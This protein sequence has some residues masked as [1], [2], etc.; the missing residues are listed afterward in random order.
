MFAPSS[1]TPPEYYEVL[2]AQSFAS[3]VLGVSQGSQKTEPALNSAEV[4]SES[5]SKPR[6]SRT[7]IVSAVSRDYK[8][9]LSLF[10]CELILDGCS[11]SM[12]KVSGKGKKLH[13]EGTLLAADAY[14]EPPTIASGV[15]IVLQAVDDTGNSVQK[16]ETFSVSEGDQLAWLRIL[17]SVLYIDDAWKH[18]LQSAALTL[19]RVV[20]VGAF[21][22]VYAATHGS[23][24][25]AV[26]VL[27][28]NSADSVVQMDFAHEAG[29]LCRLQNPNVLEFVGVATLD[30]DDVAAVAPADDGSFNP[31]QPA[32]AMAAMMNT[33]SSA[34][35]GT[36]YGIVVEFCGGGT[37]DGLITK[38]A[39]AHTSLDTTT[40]YRI[41]LGIAR[42]CEYIHALGI[43]HRDIKPENIVLTRSVKYIL[44]EEFRNATFLKIVDFGQA[45]LAHIDSSIQAI[46]D[47]GTEASEMTIKTRG[48]VFYRAPEV[49][50]FDTIN[51]TFAKTDM[52]LYSAKADIYSASLVMWEC[53]TRERPFTDARFHRAHN[54]IIEKAV[55]R[56]ERPEIPDDC[57]PFLH[58]LL[59]RGWC[60][61]P[62]LRLPASAMLDV[63]LREE[64]S[65]REG[66]T[67]LLHPQEALLKHVDAP[68]AIVTVASQH[69][70][71]FLPGSCR[72]EMLHVLEKFYADDTVVCAVDSHVQQSL[73]QRV[74]ELVEH[75]DVLWPAT[76][77]S[78]QVGAT[79]MPLLALGLVTRS[80]VQDA[81][82]DLILSEHVNLE[83]YANSA[84]TLLMKLVLRMCRAAGPA[85]EASQYVMNILSHLAAMAIPQ[86]CGIADLVRI[87]STSFGMLLH[88]YDVWCREVED[89]T[90]NSVS[91]QRSG[92]ID[93]ME[94]VEQWARYF[95]TT[96]FHYKEYAVSDVKRKVF[97]CLVASQVFP[98][99]CATANALLSPD[100]I[101]P[102]AT[103]ASSGIR[104]TD[105]E[106]ISA[107]TQWAATP[108]LYCTVVF[109]GLISRQNNVSTDS[110]T[111]ILLSWLKRYPLDT[112]L[113]AEYT[114]FL[115][116][117][118]A[119][120]DVASFVGAMLF[121]IKQHISCAP[122]IVQQ[123][124]EDVFAA[125]TLTALLAWLVKF[126]ECLDIGLVK[127][128]ITIIEVLLCDNVQLLSAQHCTAAD[129]KA[130]LNIVEYFLTKCRLSS[131]DEASTLFEICYTCLHIPLHICRHTA[132]PQVRAAFVCF[133]PLICTALLP[134]V[135]MSSSL[136]SRISDL[137]VSGRNFVKR[138]FLDSWLHGKLCEQQILDVIIHEA[139]TLVDSMAIE[140][141]CKLIQVI[142]SA[143][144]SPTRD[145]SF[146]DEVRQSKQFTQLLSAAFSLP[147]RAQA[148][149]FS[150]GDVNDVLLLLPLCFRTAAVPL[151]DYLRFAPNVLGT[152][153][154]VAEHTTDT[155][156]ASVDSS[157][158]ACLMKSAK[159]HAA[160]SAGYHLISMLTK[161]ILGT[162]T[163][164]DAMPTTEH[165][166]QL[167]QH[168]CADELEVPDVCVTMDVLRSLYCDV[169]IVPDDAWEEVIDTIELMWAC[170]EVV[171]HRSAN[172]MLQ[173]AEVAVDLLYRQDFMRVSVGL[174]HNNSILCIARMFHSIIQWGH[175]DALCNMAHEG[176]PWLQCL[177]QW[178]WRLKQ[179]AIAQDFLAIAVQIVGGL[180]QQRSSL[181]LLFDRSQLKQA[182]N[183][184]ARDKE[185][186][187]TSGIILK[188]AQGFCSDRDLLKKCGDDLKQFAAHVQHMETEV[189]K[190]KKPTGRSGSTANIIPW[191]HPFEKWTQVFDFII[192]YISEHPTAKYS[193]IMLALEDAVGSDTVERERYR[194]PMLLKQHGKIHQDAPSG[195]GHVAGI[196][197]MKSRKLR[198]GWSTPRKR[199]IVLQDNEIRY[200]SEDVD[201][202]TTKG[203]DSDTDLKGSI[204][205]IKGM[206]VTLDG[207]I[208]TFGSHGKMKACRLEF[209]GH[210]DAAIWLTKIQQLVDHSSA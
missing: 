38:H 173:M 166:Q 93:W 170:Q 133:V 131:V 141:A 66:H 43:I 15:S 128:T 27:R 40:F 160:C 41:A 136:Q 206:S 106:T 1:T 69:A 183:I 74:R 126:K 152:M 201:T 7:G 2:R 46:D 145:K 47:D 179:D 125:G 97:S 22:E 195:S 81:K 37:L 174:A 49:I 30:P 86:A 42:G 191:T 31:L 6:F 18:P 138:L 209:Q 99:L 208:I 188:A 87:A 190:A 167:L 156:R 118:D 88:R 105:A 146:G 55:A 48:T 199:W 182:T 154:A 102:H 198:V 148:L 164:N 25:V 96:T 137:V 65:H 168:L 63:L 203:A 32:A 23:R 3:D 77:P 196:W 178:C 172:T 100:R 82:E 187:K 68:A 165:R 140:E 123:R 50:G 64:E 53:W 59:S 104:N 51:S 9:Q 116:P 19:N 147:S 107:V 10:M 202:T 169:A 144:T 124:F 39:A 130:L 176:K 151:D 17:N 83:G 194:I 36:L 12:F 149:N 120:E 134:V 80:L 192:S 135:N 34:Q 20:G 204:P 56:G 67:V 157:M 33:D 16:V 76:D 108:A 28:G 91:G 94:V 184:F 143:I 150:G 153:I 163:Q 171:L 175:S 61:I 127:R 117:Y 119:P 45:A 26:K 89:V 73:I 103:F 158:Q 29:I 159:I 35:A 62:N 44:E 200:F 186:I 11:I 180:A 14:D 75:Q 121:C 112:T 79:R 58:A 139:V 78:Q 113:R 132:M 70:W 210:L 155:P 197:V 95:M 114:Q 90:V 161:W 54:I 115:Q 57:P 207:S 109:G 24:E 101:K 111:P 84:F 193:D 122:I 142:A 189:A 21:G 181:L 52:A 85:V 92:G 110:F 177:G 129:A 162:T 13:R 185:V 8:Q 98:K 71:Q 205:L 60:Q 4:G 5:V 72:D